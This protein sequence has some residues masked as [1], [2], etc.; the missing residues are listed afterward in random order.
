[1]SLGVALD[2]SSMPRTN[3]L[4]ERRER[5]PFPGEVCLKLHDWEFSH[6]GQG[7]SSCIGH[8]GQDPFG[9]IGYPGGMAEL[10]NNIRALR[11]Q[12][13]LT[14]EELAA[15]TPHPKPDTATD[16]TT[17]QKLE[18]GKRRLTTDWMTRIAHA[19]GVDQSDLL[20][21]ATAVKAI[22]KVPRIGSIPGGDWKAAI[23][24]PLDLI[25]TTKGGPNTFALTVDGDSMDK[26]VESGTTIFIDPDDR[27]LVDE[28]YYA[29][30]RP[31]GEVTFKQ[32][33]V[34]PLRL[35]PCSSNQAHRTIMIG[36]EPLTTLGRVVGYE[37]D[38]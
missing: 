7:V 10:P 34:D 15:L 13:G 28:R 25:P 8:A 20:L 1:M 33:R 23:E 30:L 31:G 27:A 18:L 35:E 38:L 16:L 6:N 37:G 36:D 12:R 9:H 29:V 26:V 21:V 32:F 5:Q 2:G 14:L 24:E 4:G 17:I 19:L 22:R 11:L 3:S